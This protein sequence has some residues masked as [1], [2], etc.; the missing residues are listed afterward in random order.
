[1]MLGFCLYILL[2]KVIV[3]F[4]EMRRYKQQ[5]TEDECREILNTETSGVLAVSG[6]DGYPYA[7]PMSFVC[8]DNKIYF[9]CAKSG[10]K[11]DAVK[12]ESKASFC[13]IHK[14]DVVPE[15]F[16][17][18]YKSVIVFG[19]VRIIDSGDEM[20]NAA[21]ILGKKYYPKVAENVLDEE[22]TKFKDNMLILVLEAEHITGKC[23]KELIRK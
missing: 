13:V 15:E 6:D 19:K 16:T 4:R 12:R 1:M 23:A 18:Y 20:V 17:T 5:M 3:L 8:N 21:R 22:I 9:H 7:V 2:K 10:H 14:D 11:L